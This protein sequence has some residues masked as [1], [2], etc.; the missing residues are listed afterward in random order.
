MK[1]QLHH[2][3]SETKTLDVLSTAPR[4]PVGLAYRSLQQQQRPLN[5]PR[6]EQQVVR[7]N[8]EK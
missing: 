6:W 5:L 2:L 3:D 1:L 4:V 7:Q 8:E